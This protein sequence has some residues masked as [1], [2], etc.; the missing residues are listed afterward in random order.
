[1]K[2]EYIKFKYNLN[3]NESGTKE[4]GTFH[5]HSSTRLFSVYAT[6]QKD[7][8]IYPPNGNYFGDEK[9][10]ESLYIKKNKIVENICS[11]YNV[12]GQSLHCDDGMEMEDHSWMYSGSYCCWSD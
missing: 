7:G 9:V 5:I 10:K 6:K 3:L 12:G 1:M 8:S 11:L 2:E 4:S